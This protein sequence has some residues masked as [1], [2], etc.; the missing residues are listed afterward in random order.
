MLNPHLSIGTLFFALRRSLK[1]QKNQGFFL[2]LNQIQPHL[3]A[4]IG[5]L[6]QR[7]KAED[8]FLYLVATQDADKGQCHT[9]H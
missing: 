9:S 7:F 1:L 4:K 8:G 6:H 2:F 5:D 3:D